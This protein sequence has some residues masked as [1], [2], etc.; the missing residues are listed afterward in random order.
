MAAPAS[1][2]LIINYLPQSLTDEEF[3]SMF[4]S[5]GPLKASKIV[6]DR[7]TNYSYGFGFVEYMNDDDAGKAIATLN[8]LQLQNK[9]I[10]VAYSRNGDK[11]KGANLYV[12]NVPKHFNQEQFQAIFQNHGTII[13]A[14]IISDP[15]TGDSKGIGFVLFDTKDQAESAI[16]E[17]DGTIPV[18]G[19]ES[20]SVK[21]ADD[22]VG[23]ARAPQFMAAAAAGRG[24]GGFQQGY[25]SSYG[26]MRNRGPMNRYNPIGGGQAM[27][28][29]GGGYSGYAG[30]FYED[31]SAYGQNGGG[32]VAAAAPGGG[33]G[34]GG[35]QGGFV[36]FVYNI[37]PDANE[38]GIWQLFAPFGNI[39][40]V[41]VIRD[42][43]KD[44][45]KGYGF[46]TMSSYAE[47][48]NAIQQLNGYKYY[49]KPL[50]VSFKSGNKK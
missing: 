33:A 43:Q 20:L 48:M 36:L 45:G 42:F 5:I 24:A 14:R 29:P 32:G 30:G 35:E 18:G 41:N 49:G 27:G 47:A 38:N 34:G 6:R 10:K 22:N 13:Q 39:I 3:R 12:R 16:A 44:V 50:Q 40:K 8:G 2:N 4:L 7:A 37:G 21:F 11:V 9:R 23:K 1:S 28:P 19:T 46:V 17:L 25:A 31:T 15:N 26:P